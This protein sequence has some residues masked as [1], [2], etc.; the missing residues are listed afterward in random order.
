[1]FTEKQPFCHYLGHFNQ[2]TERLSYISALGERVYDTALYYPVSDFQERLKA[3]K[4]SKEFDTLGRA[5]ENKLIDFDIV[6]DDVLQMSEITDDGYMCI[7]SA[8]YKHIIV[9]KDAYIPEATRIALDNFIKCGGYVSHELSNLTPVVKSAGVGLRAM[10]RKVENGELLIL[11]RETGENGDYC[12]HLPSTNGYLLDLTN[13]ELQYLKT[14]NGILK[15]SLAIGETAVVLLTDEVLKAENKK[16]FKEKFD[17]TSDFTFHKETELVCDENGFDNI[18]HSEKS[19][20]I[21]LGDWSQIIGSTYSGSGV[22]ETHF[23]LPAEKVGKEAELNLGDVH[24]VASVSLNEHYLGAKLAPPYKF[25]I[26]TGILNENNM[27]KITV[28]NTSANWYVNTDYFKRWKTKEL[29]QYFDGEIEYAKDFVTGGL[30]G[31]V[32]IYTE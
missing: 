28:T 26:P 20:P 23:S 31:P 5:L 19:V 3:E 6:D 7:G 21:K 4:L 24:F 18:N 11:F 16:C 2:Y 29:S 8:K 25:K 14:E 1:V 13:G 12:I 30:Y 10:H 22:Y 9:P 32:T 15:L 17:I 27:L